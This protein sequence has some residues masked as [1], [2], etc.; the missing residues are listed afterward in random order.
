LTEPE[1][2]LDLSTFLKQTA[3]MVGLVIPAENVEGVLAHLERMREMAKSLM[4][5]A[6]ADDV[7]SAP[8]FE[9]EVFES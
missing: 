6:I 9:P 4:S 1:K 7:E 5:V 3:E 8:V 2:S